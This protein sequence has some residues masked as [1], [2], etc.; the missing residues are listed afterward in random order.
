MM[1]PIHSAHL[2]QPVQPARHSNPNP[3]ANL[4][5]LLGL[6]FSAAKNPEQKGF[7]QKTVIPAIKRVGAVAGKVSAVAG[8]VAVV[9]SII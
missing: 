4:N 5:H 8:K 3:N 1:S 9:A 2:A 6:S 7:L